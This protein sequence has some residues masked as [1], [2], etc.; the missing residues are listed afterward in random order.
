MAVSATRLKPD[1]FGSRLHC[2]IEFVVNTPT[3]WVFLKSA[4]YYDPL[5]LQRIGARG[6]RCFRIVTHGLGF[7]DF[8]FLSHFY[9]S[10]TG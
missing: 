5:L 9:I 2:K 8:G 4:R 1:R 7:A 6:V 3:G 10:V